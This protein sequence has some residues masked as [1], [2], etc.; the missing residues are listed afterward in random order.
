MSCIVFALVGHVFNSYTA[1]HHIQWGTS[2]SLWPLSEA[3]WNTYTP[4]YRRE[5]DRVYALVKSMFVPD[6]I[7][8]RCR[9]RGLTCLSAFFSAGALN[10]MQRD[11]C[12]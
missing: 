4:T 11:I 7:A 12:K 8:S 5:P 10:E 2:P 3:G 1:Y 6:R 9:L